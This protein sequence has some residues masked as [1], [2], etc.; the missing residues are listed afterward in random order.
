MARQW[1]VCSCCAVGAKEHYDAS[2]ARYWSTRH[3]PNT[4]ACVWSGIYK[5]AL[6]VQDWRYCSVC[7]TRIPIDW[8]YNHARHLGW[9]TVGNMLVT[10][11]QQLVQELIGILERPEFNER[12]RLGLA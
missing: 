10:L 8:E 4:C 6:D 9:G 7:V 1:T 3:R 11:V 12:K 2:R 5:Q